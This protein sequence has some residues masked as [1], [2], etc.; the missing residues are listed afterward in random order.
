MPFESFHNFFKKAESTEEQPDKAPDSFE[1]QAPPPENDA[2]LSEKE[3]DE[4]W[5]RRSNR[6]L[7]EHERAAAAKRIEENSRKLDQ[8]IREDQAEW[9]RR[10]APN[11]LRREALEA[12][13][14]VEHELDRALDQSA[15][16]VYKK[17]FLSLKKEELPFQHFFDL[18]NSARF[19]D[20]WKDCLPQE[21]YEANRE[22]IHRCADE[23]KRIL[24]EYR[25]WAS[26]HEHPQDATTALF[27]LITHL[28]RIDPE[29]FPYDLIELSDEDF[30]S[31][32]SGGFSI[33]DGRNHVRMVQARAML[34]EF[35]PARFRKILGAEYS[36]EYVAKTQ[37]YLEEWDLGHPTDVP[38]CLHAWG[39]IA[40]A[41]GHRKVP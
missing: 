9:K 31:I 28:H 2:L 15:E 33:N 30:R 23:V 37:K 14:S 8:R 21:T 13:P 12:L 26:A 38:K 16:G 11:I 41:L 39:E 32:G 6:F 3:L 34:A 19:L 17:D 7:P 22:K 10:E 20:E 27:E 1:H 4:L 25:S 18:N 5:S 24:D 29:S 36:P 35:D 40:R